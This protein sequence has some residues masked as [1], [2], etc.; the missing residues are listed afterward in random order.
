MA[1]CIAILAFALVIIGHL[2]AVTSVL[3]HTRPRKA[4]VNVSFT[5]FAGVAWRAVAAVAPNFIHTGPIVQTFG[6]PRSGESG[7]VIFINFT[8]HSKGSWRTG[9][10]VT[11]NKVNTGPSILTWVRLAL[12]YVY[13]TVCS[14]KSGHTLT[15]ITTKVAVARPSIKT[16]IGVTLVDGR[17]TVAA[18]VAP[19]AETLVRVSSVHTGSPSMAELIHTNTFPAR[20]YIT[21]NT[22]DITV[23]SRPSRKTL[24]A[25][26]WA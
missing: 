26:R 5:S 1:S 22:W 16:R 7:A 11:T 2:D 20:C 8:Q 21:K 13:F 9:A 18:S 6:L 25:D 10:D 19:S 24:T 4:L 3:C 23:T 12:V 14:F 17:L 15:H